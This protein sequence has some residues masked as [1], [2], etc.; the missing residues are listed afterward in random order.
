[1][2]SVCDTYYVDSEHVAGLVKLGVTH[3]MERHI[4]EDSPFMNEKEVCCVFPDIR[5]LHSFNSAAHAYIINQRIGSMKTIDMQTRLI[6][7]K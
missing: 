1:M 3:G 4:I 6:R 7:Q 2:I 5:A